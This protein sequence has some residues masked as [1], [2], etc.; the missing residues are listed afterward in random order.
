MADTTASGPGAPGPGRTIVSTRAVASVA[1]RAA[2]EVP[3]V[4]LVSRAGLLDRLGGLLPG[5]GGG[6]G[7][8]SAEVA[9]G[10]TDIELRL[11]VGW[12][13]PVSRVA[14]EAR[15]HVRSR[16]EELTGYTVNRVDIVVDL[17]SDEPADQGRTE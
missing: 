2:T 9:G 12:P 3:G 14:D 6:A 7:A 8:A 4:A 10:S 13:R 17:L 5:S 11:G 15:R 1:H 16:V